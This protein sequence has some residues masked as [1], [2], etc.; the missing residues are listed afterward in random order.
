MVHSRLLLHNQ[1]WA[2][3]DPAA[4]ILVRWH[5]PVIVKS[6]TLWGVTAKVGTSSN[7][8]NVMEGSSSLS[9]VL[10][11]PTETHRAPCSMVTWQKGSLKLKHVEI[12]KIANKCDAL[13]NDHVILFC[14]NFNFLP[15]LTSFTL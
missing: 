4:S 5:I 6:Y 13:S 11:L 3:V 1:T 8:L 15:D 14:F 9:I 7:S 2:I 12:V 10:S